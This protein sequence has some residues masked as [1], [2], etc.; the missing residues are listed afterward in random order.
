[1]GEKAVAEEVI[2]G[3]KLLKHLV[4]GQ[5]SQ[6]WEVVEVSSHRHFGMKMLLPEKARDPFHRRLLA[7]EAE[8]GKELAHPNIIKIVASSMKGD[9]PYMV[10]E[11][12]PAGN[13][14]LRL[15][16][17]DLAFIRERCQD[18]LKQAA[19]ALAFMNAKGWVHRDVKPDNFL[20]N[21][22]GELRLIDFALAQ[23][24]KKG[25]LPPT[26][27]AALAGILGGALV[28][29]LAAAY[30]MGLF[31][32][33]EMDY[34][35]GQEAAKP[36]NAVPVT[37]ALGLAGGVVGGAV[38]GVVGRVFRRQSKAQGTRSYMSPEQIRGQALD[39]R[40]DIY[41]FGATAYELATGRPPFRGMSNQDLLNKHIVEKPTSPQMYNADITDEFAAL[42]LRMLS[43][44]KQERPRDFH[45][46]LMALRTMRVFKTESGQPTRK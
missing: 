39:G 13:L 12:F 42:V 35:V 9:T 25:G 6:V 11:F 41:S 38:G 22:A 23:K 17:K 15:I 31:S 4:T 21:S 37:L 34:T 8:V 27:T 19:T 1:V 24:I 30:A 28:V 36:K 45:E 29:G 14:K 10:M 18:I 26:V 44:K 43:K 46:V 2:G 16:R 33:P 7:H 40:A 32:G 20:V 3:Y 5:T